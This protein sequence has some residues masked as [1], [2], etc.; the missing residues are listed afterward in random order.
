MDQKLYYVYI[1]RSLANPDF[2]YTGRTRDPEVRLADHN[3][4]KR[5]YSK[6]HRPWRIKTLIAFTDRSKA[7]SFERYLKTRSGRAFARKRL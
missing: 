3:S 7:V 6:E 4:G 1:L 2:H 5:S